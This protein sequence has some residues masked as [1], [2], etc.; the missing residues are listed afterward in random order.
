[1]ENSWHIHLI[2]SRRR[3]VGI[4]IEDSGEITVRA[5]LRMPEREIRQVLESKR[6]AP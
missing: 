3:S 2:R 5:P 6:T 1:M 4:R